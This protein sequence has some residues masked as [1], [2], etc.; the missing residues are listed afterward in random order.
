ME[1]V[2]VARI[3]LFI[4]FIFMIY[5]AIGYSIFCYLIFHYNKEIDAII[6]VIISIFFGSATK[7]FYEFILKSVDSNLEIKS[8][9]SKKIKAFF[10]GG[11]SVLQIFTSLAFVCTLAFNKYNINISNLSAIGLTLFG[12]AILLLF[13]WGV[14]NT[15]QKK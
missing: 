10:D 4:Y 9:M 15:L 2:K 14:S 12:F 13:I 3:Y 7:D 5:I 8:V 1:K 11:I 6:T